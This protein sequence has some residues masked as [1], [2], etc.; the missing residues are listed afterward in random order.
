MSDKQERKGRELVSDKQERKISEK[1]TENKLYSQKEK[2]QM[3]KMN[4]FSHLV[5]YSVERNFVEESKRL[6]VLTLFHSNEPSMKS[7][8]KENLIECEM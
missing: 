3:F 8:K 7:R 4:A 1:M 6:N 2:R 5:I